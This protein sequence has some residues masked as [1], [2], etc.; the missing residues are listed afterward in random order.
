MVE[1]LFAVAPVGCGCG[2]F[3]L[4]PCFLICLLVQFLV[5]IS[6]HHAEE[7]SWLLYYN[8]D[9]ASCVLCPFLMVPWVCLQSVVVTFPGHMHL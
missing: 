4:G 9:V 8:C 5:H 3:M 1:T 2:S 6:N 7:E